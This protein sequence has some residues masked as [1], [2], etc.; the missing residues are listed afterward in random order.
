MPFFLFVLVFQDGVG[1]VF[2]GLSLDAVA[3][4]IV[5]SAQPILH[6]VLCLRAVLLHL[7]HRQHKLN[8]LHVKC[9]RQPVGQA[10]PVHGIVTGIFV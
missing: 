7:V 6:G 9:L 5:H 2:G 3:N 10:G 1:L 4:Q 8:L